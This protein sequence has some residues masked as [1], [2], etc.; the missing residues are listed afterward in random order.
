VDRL[1]IALPAALGVALLATAARGDLGARDVPTVFHIAKSENRNQ[2]HYGVHLDAA[3]APAGAAPAFAYWRM[4]EHGPLATEPLLDREQGAY[5]F[6]DQRVLEG[7]RVVLR[8]RALPAR[9]IVVQTGHEGDAC[10]AV[11]TTTIGGAPAVL[12]SVFVQ[13]RWPFGVDHLVLAGHRT[14]DG[15]AVQEKL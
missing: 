14:A 2:V 5:G 11:A 12:D 6:A 9:S 15:A 1:A 10:S 3:C 8:L 13:L 7:G 4:L